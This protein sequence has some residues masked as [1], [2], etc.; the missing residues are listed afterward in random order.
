MTDEFDPY[1]LWLGISP[2]DQPPNHYRLLGIDLLEGNAEV[3]QAAADRQM[4]HLRSYQMGEYAGLSQKLLNE[5]AQAKLC[6]LNPVKKAE[7]D[8]WLHELAGSLLESKLAGIEQEDRTL[9]TEP[10]EEA[11][12]G[13]QYQIMGEAVGPVSDDELRA[14]VAEG[15]VT[16]D[17][18][19]N[20]EGKRRESVPDLL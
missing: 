3:I 14:L 17:T 1:Y 16:G 13:W 9:S 12:V 6:L 19:V 20:R 11:R 5:V 10:E 8:E 4:K 15:R 7:N 2:R 18:L